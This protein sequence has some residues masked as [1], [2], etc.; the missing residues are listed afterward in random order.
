ML[1]LSHML[2]LSLRRS[3]TFRTHASQ[4]S[5]FSELR[6]LKLLVEESLKA[7]ALPHDGD[8]DEADPLAAQQSRNLQ[9]LAAAAEKF[10]SAASSTASTR[11]SSHWGSEAG[12]PRLTLAQRERIELWN[13]RHTVAESVPDGSPTYTGAASPTGGYPNPGANR[14]SPELVK[15]TGLG[16]S[17][18][19]LAIDNDDDD[20]DSESSGSDIESDFLKNFES[21]AYVSFQ[22]QNYSKAEQLL[23]MA[24]E[25]ST[26]DRSGAV[27][28]KS[29]KLK[30]ALCCCL[31]EKWDHAAGIVASLP[32][33]RT[34]ANLPIFHLL[35]AMSLAHLVGNRCDDAYAVCKSA[36]NGKKKILGRTSVD[37]YGCLTVFAA[38]CE[39][40]GNALEAEAVRHSIPD[41]WSPRTSVI[42][43]SPTQYIL[44]HETLI[45][46]VFSPGSAAASDS[47]PPST[48]RR[49]NPSV[50]EAAWTSTT[51]GRWSTTSGHWSTLLPPAQR[52]GVEA[53][54][55]NEG[56]GTV[57][58]ETDTGKELLTG[59]HPEAPASPPPPRHAPPPIPP[60]PSAQSWHSADDL[61][62]QRSPEVPQSRTQTPSTQTRSIQ[63]PSIQTPSTQ[64][65]SIQIHSPAFIEQLGGMGQGDEYV[66]TLEA[67]PGQDQDT[68]PPQAQILQARGRG[69]TF[70]LPTSPPPRHPPSPGLGRTR[71]IVPRDISNI[72]ERRPLGVLGP[73]EVLVV[74]PRHNSSPNNARSVGVAIIPDSAD[75]VAIG[76]R[77]RQTAVCEVPPD[78]SVS[79]ISHTRDEAEFVKLF[80]VANDPPP[81]QAQQAFDNLSPRASGGSVAG[82]K[83]LLRRVTSMRGR[84]TSPVGAPKRHRLRSKD[85]GDH[86]LDLSPAEVALLVE[87]MAR[88]ERAIADQLRS[89][90][91]ESPPAGAAVRVDAVVCAMQ[92]AECYPAA[93]QATSDVMASCPLFQHAK[94]I[95]FSAAAMQY[96][97][98]TGALALPRLTTTLNVLALTCS[99]ALVE[100]SPYILQTTAPDTVT[101]T[102]SDMMYMTEFT[103]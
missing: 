69:D 90:P 46:S 23:R 77:N 9:S 7:A 10:H 25:Q 38:I 47:G 79:S 68:G 12:G 42:V 92:G 80:S 58:E 19:S 87:D 59:D 76:I 18:G 74:R 8:P 64:T 13:D 70:P 54:R 96:F 95:S 32:K 88:I 51:S 55:R 26:G 37:Y 35:Q 60:S 72:G 39:K 102:E 57:V 15:E 66:S 97:L 65:P 75:N 5:L 99:D 6:N 62:F 33:T 43:S 11:Y 21:L 48:Q 50:S 78:R 36:L 82:M 41:G 16:V 28:F 63:T 30:L 71:W 85:P 14:L 86:P 40:R 52:D 91:A 17:L 45:K 56:S 103:G 2:T 61:Q 84:G 3:L 100:C 81:Q 93:W 49:D 67:M 94:L 53:A 83:K 4:E 98:D 34:P 89:D 31:Q 73:P 29:L 27:D 101:V 1:T 22:G 24:V 20:D 44:Q